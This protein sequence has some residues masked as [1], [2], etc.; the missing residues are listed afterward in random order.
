M[1]SSPANSPAPLSSPNAA[2]R[3]DGGGAFG[4]SLAA[5]PSSAVVTV[6]LQITGEWACMEARMSISRVIRGLLV[7]MAAPQL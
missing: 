6:S 7:A 2:R 3:R 5:S 4:S 1:S